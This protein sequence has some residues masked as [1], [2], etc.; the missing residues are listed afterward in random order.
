MVTVGSHLTN[1]A[2]SW[3]SPDL[4]GLNLSATASLRDSQRGD[5]LG[6]NYMTV[7]YTFDDAHFAYASEDTSEG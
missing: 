2:S 6:S 3:L 5:G 7:D 4:Q 1:N